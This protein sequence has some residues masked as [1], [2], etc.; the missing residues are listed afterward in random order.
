MFPL[1]KTNRKCISALV[2]QFPVFMFALL[3]TGVACRVDDRRS[4]DSGTASAGSGSTAD[5]ATG[6]GGGAGTGGSSSTGGATGSGGSSSQYANFA[7]VSQIVQI[8]CAGSGCHNGD[9]PPTMAGIGDAKLYT[10]LTTFVS[11]LCGNRV[12]VMPGLPDQSAFYLAQKGLCGDY[13][14][15]MPLGCVDNCTPADYLD[16]VQQWIANGAPQ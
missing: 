15:Q 13:L 9:T 11:T 12:L 16:G 10:A 3:V 1:L 5:G 8:K 2:G 4:I 7:T 6:G 14:P